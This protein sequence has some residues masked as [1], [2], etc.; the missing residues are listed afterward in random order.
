MPQ[1]NKTRIDRRR[2]LLL[3]A[4]TTNTDLTP[5]EYFIWSQIGDGI[6][7]RDLIPVCPWPAKETLEKIESLISKTSAEWSN[8]SRVSS[9][10]EYKKSNVVLSPDIQKQLNEDEKDPELQDLDRN[11]RI[12]I[13]KKYLEPENLNPYEILEIRSKVSPQELKEQYLALSK[14]FHPDRFFRKKLGPYKPKLD[15][16]FTRIQKAYGLL[17]N[18]IEREALDRTM[19]LHTEKAEKKSPRKILKL[20]K[21]TEK[22]GKAEHHYKTGLELE[23]KLD[24]VGAFNLFVMASQ[25]DSKREV[26]KT[27]LDRV[28]PRVNKEKAIRLLESVKK[29]LEITG[30]TEELFAELEKAVDLDSSLSEAQF[31]LA[32][33]IIDLSFTERFRDAKEM[34]LRAKTTHSK[35]A[36][37]NYYLARVLI[38]LKDNKGA[39]KELKEGLQKDPNHPLSNKLLEKLKNL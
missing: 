17:K 31:L 10:S 2:H 9:S 37:A 19:A 13:L 32:R 15:S 38:G 16:V 33:F 35:S 27:A 18:P 4:K 7:L 5:E 39:T 21:N 24:F 25:I 26:Y 22:I 30:P 14:K 34:L 12:E 23:K 11:F 29:S 28:R 6:K 20:D 8:P 1:S 3:K 36:D